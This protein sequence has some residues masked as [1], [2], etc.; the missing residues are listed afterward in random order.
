[1]DNI[2]VNESTIILYKLYWIYIRTFISLFA[3]DIKQTST[4]KAT[5]RD[6]TNLYRISQELLIAACYSSYLGRPDD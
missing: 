1:M 5:A 2:N 6:I 4:Q 3:R